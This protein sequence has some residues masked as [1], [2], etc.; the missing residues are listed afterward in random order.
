MEWKSKVVFI[1][2]ASKSM[3]AWIAK[4]FAKLGSKVVIGYRSSTSEAEK[5]VE[6][7]KKE[8]NNQNV[9]SE[10][11]D[12][13][14]REMVNQVIT[15]IISNHK[16]IDLL[17]N[18]AGVSYGGAI[19]P[20]AQTD[21]WDEIIQTNIMGTINC[22][23]AVSFHML[24]KRSGSIVNL[25]SLAGLIGQERLSVYSASKSAVIGLTRS[26]S[27]DYASYNVRVNIVAPG[28]IEDTGMVNAIPPEQMADFKKRIAMGHLGEREDIAHAIEFL[29]SDKAK[30][31]TG[32]TLVVDGGLM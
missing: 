32:Q 26:L 6:K 25:S 21:K 27:K 3:G 10:Q 12:V 4:H 11:I 13:T 2:G 17:V 28:F 19:I 14:D 29:A 8:T 16:R 18:N 5:V 30:Y 22:I 9:F 24:T 23:Q 20:G 15:N 1:T 7:I 31:I